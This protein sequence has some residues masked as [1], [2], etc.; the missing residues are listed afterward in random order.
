[1]TYAYEETCEAFCKLVLLMVALLLAT[2]SFLAPSEARAA[3]KGPNFKDV[4]AIQGMQLDDTVVQVEMIMKSLER[5][6]TEEM[7]QA[8]KK[9]GDENLD[10]VRMRKSIK[11]V[12]ISV[13]PAVVK[14]VL[15]DG[16]F[17]SGFLIHSA[18]YVLTNRHV[19]I[20]PAPLTMLEKPGTPNEEKPDSPK[21]EIN[22]QEKFGERAPTVKAT[23]MVVETHDNRKYPAHLVTTANLNDLAL[24]KIESNRADWPTLTFSKDSEEEIDNTP[25]IALG[26]PMGLPLTVTSGIISGVGR[27]GMTKQDRSRYIQTDAC[28]NP[29][30]SGGPLVDMKGEVVGVNTWIISPGRIFVG[31]DGLGFAISAPDAESFLRL[32]VGLAKAEQR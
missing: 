29:G 30:N 8:L 32:A 6:S 23:T 7:G 21:D 2:V 20:P 24:I 14:I 22:T 15:K 27:H 25:V 13:K 16:G 19:V 3:V 17:G 31:C 28:I 11:E 12:L 26:Y 1:M 18:G 5:L 9:L 10:P 4:P